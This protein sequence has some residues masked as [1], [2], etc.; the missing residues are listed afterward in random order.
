MTQAQTNERELVSP[1]TLACAAGFAAMAQNAGFRLAPSS[2]PTGLVR[3][4]TML[5]PEPR[6]RLETACTRKRH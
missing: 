2:L 6:R 3:I 5:P 1:S 4:I